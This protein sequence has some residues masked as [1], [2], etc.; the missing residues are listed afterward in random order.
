M[1][2]YTSKKSRIYYL[3]KKI[4]PTS[5]YYNKLWV[6]TVLASP[7]PRHK[8]ISAVVAE[9]IIVAVTITIAIAVAGWLLGVWNAESTQSIY[10]PVTVTEN[11]P[12][13][14]AYYPVPGYFRIEVYSTQ[15]SQDLYQVCVKITAVKTLSRVEVTA[16]ITANDGDPPDY[17]GEQYATVTWSDNNIYPEWYSMRCWMPIRQDEY[18]VTI[19]LHIYAWESK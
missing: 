13:D 12:N 3:N 9:I 16:S 18:P 11:T 17:V 1:F 6:P 8:G 4:F 5:N 19:R 14:N 2:Y 15:T 7:R 10:F